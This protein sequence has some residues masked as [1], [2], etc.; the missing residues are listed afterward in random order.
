[1]VF[2]DF[3]RNLMTVGSSKKNVTHTGVY[4]M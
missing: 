4:P 1:M 3:F 2:S